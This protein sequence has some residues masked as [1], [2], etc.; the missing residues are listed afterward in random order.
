V[1]KQSAKVQS[2]SAF[3]WSIA[4]ILRGDLNFLPSIAK[5]AIGSVSRCAQVTLTQSWHGP[6]QSA[7]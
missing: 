5:P 3:A 7:P 1:A 2:L 6:H 4:D